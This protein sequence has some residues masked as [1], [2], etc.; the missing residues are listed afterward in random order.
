[1]EFLVL[2]GV[3]VLLFMMGGLRGRLRELEATLRRLDERLMNFDALPRAPQ[4]KAVGIPGPTPLLDPEPQAEGLG[5][6]LLDVLGMGAA[7]EG[8]GQAGGVEDQPQRA[9]GDVA[10]LGVLRDER[11]R[12]ALEPGEGGDDLAPAVPDHLG[13]GRLGL[14]GRGGGGR[15]W[16]RGRGGPTLGGTARDEAYALI[17]AFAGSNSGRSDAR[18]G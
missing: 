17:F 15:G 8:G 6:G 5:E 3:V 9:A 14:L 18:A 12:G 13:V 10:H 4:P 7:A 2:V 1:M 16:R 11:P